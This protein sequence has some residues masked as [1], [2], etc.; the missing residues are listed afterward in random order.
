LIR[1]AIRFFLQLGAFG[2]IAMGV[3]DSSFLF[4]PFG[5]DLLVVALTARNPDKFWLYAMAAAAGSLLGCTLTDFVSRKIGEAGLEKLVGRGKLEQVQQR[6]KKHTFWALGAAAL[7]PPPFP[8][9]VFL[10]AASAIQIARWRVLTAVG[11]GR[12]VRFVTLGLLAARFGRGILRLSQRDEVQYF[13]VALAVVSIVGSA[14]SIT[15]WVRSSRGGRG[16]VENARA[17]AG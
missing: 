16:P 7:L 8:F 1:S 6:L 13:V 14:V 9:T 12:L 5:N 17:E 3:L 2:L 10:I 11:I 4:L 15:K